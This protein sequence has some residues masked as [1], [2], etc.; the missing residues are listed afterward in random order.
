MV[1]LRILD[2]Q[3]VLLEQAAVNAQEALILVINQYK[4]G[5]VAYASVANAEI[6]AFTAQKNLADIQGLRMTTAVG[7]IKALGGGWKLF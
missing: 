7:L 4:A 2:A 3:S 1:A 5:T 6:S